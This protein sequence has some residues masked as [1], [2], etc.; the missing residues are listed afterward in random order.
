MFHNNQ[1][2][3]LSQLLNLNK[4]FYQLFQP[5]ML[6][7]L[8]RIKEMKRK[9]ENSTRIDSHRIIIFVSLWAIFLILPKF[10]VATQE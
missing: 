9:F 4:L 2:N 10:C 5:Q 3:K 8:E 6:A 1:L 7:C